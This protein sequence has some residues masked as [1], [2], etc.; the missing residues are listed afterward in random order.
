MI[1]HIRYRSQVC[2]ANLLLRG[3][4]LSEDEADALDG[5]EHGAHVSLQK[6]GKRRHHAELP[7]IRL[8]GP[9]CTVFSMLGCYS[10]HSVLGVGHN[11]L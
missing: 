9:L 1:N 2:K 4:C 6:K 11:L 5:H 10:E 3:P 8:Q 7:V